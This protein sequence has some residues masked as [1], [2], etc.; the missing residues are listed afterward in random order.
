MDRTKAS[1]DIETLTRE[2]LA[3]ELVSRHFGVGGALLMV[4]A[5]GRLRDDD[6][7][8]RDL[9]AKMVEVMRLVDSGLLAGA[10]LPRLRELLVDIASKGG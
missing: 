10:A 3:S 7:Y 1:K 5:A 4:A 8:L 6:R 9:R 2:E